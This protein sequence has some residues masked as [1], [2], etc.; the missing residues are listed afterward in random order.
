MLLLSLICFAL[1]RATPSDP[2]AR[3]IVAEGAVAGQQEPAGYDRLYRRLA[4]RMGYD[5]PPFYFSVQNASLPDTLHRILPKAS[6]RTVRRLAYR[7]GDWPRV[8][9]YY[10]AISSAAATATDDAV[11][12]AAR[13]LL[14][15]D[16]PAYVRRQLAQ[17]GELPAARPIVE[18]YAALTEAPVRQ[19][20]L[21]PRLVWHGT[22]NQYHRYLTGVLRGDL[23]ISYTD[24]RPVREKLAAALP[25]TVRLNGI[26]LAIVYLL[27][28]PLGLY[29]AYFAGSAFDRW[30][31]LLTFLA[32]GL[33]AFWIATLLANFLTT[34]AF[35]MDWFP[36]MGY[37]TVPP[38]APWWKAL[39]IR[40]HHLAL[41]VFCLVYPSLAYVSRHLRSAAIEQLRQ[42]YVQTAYM[43][44]LTGGQVLWGH[45][46]RNAAFPL[47]T[48]LGG[49]LPAL[50]AGSVLVEQIF[51]LPG[52]GR[53]LF[54]AATAQD[55][56]VVLA[57]VL[58]NGSFTV[59]GLLLADL[60]YVLLDPRVRLGTVAPR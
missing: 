26:A 39:Q 46:F 57:L 18:A 41:P 47:V 13:R 50:L 24:G 31:T 43:K 40:I 38:G 28:V 32:F 33:P 5:L 35:G 11:L 22:R 19:R 54:D 8:E 10:T 60:G 9:A 20:V 21:L 42:P 30:A 59:I 16:E 1:S 58:V 53:L 45:V 4:R 27:A 14:L 51:N 7:F 23:G 56:P 12:A 3:H 17:L 34:P 6:R 49:L 2:V 52:M 37:G 15:N 55:W 36:S 48:L 29:M 44:S 25:L